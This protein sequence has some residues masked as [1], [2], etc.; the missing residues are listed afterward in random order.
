MIA[1]D[2]VLLPEPFGPM[3]AWTDPLSTVRSMPLRMGLP[4]TLTSRSRISR[5]DNGPLPCGGRRELGEGHA[6]ERLRDR[7]LQLEPHRARAAVRLAHAVHD[8]VSLGG[9]DLG[10]DRSLE[11]THHVARRDRPRLARE[12][13]AASRAALPVHQTGPA[14]RR[15]ELLEIGL[16][17]VLAL[18]DGVQRDRSLAPV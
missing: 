2:S 1:S 8:R 7:R 10:L 16:R 5:L 6:V 9:T 11:R 13:V 4:S 12:N 3:I 17:Q 14:E 15:D 18:R